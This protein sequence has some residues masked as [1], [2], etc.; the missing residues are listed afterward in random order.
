MPKETLKSSYTWLNPLKTID[1]QPHRTCVSTILKG[2][3]HMIMILLFGPIYL[4]ISLPAHKTQEWLDQFWCIICW[5][6]AN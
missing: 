5:I 3:S 4:Y 1:V 6:I 2:K